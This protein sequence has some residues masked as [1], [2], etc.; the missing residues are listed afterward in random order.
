MTQPWQGEGVL[1][2]NGHDKL[3]PFVLTGRRRS[4]YHLRAIDGLDVVAAPGF[5]RLAIVWPQTSAA[6]S[7]NESASTAAHLP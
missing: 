6:P 3:E 1:L 7:P 4:S 5:E 2:D